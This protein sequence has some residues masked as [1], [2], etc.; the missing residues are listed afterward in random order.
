MKYK[1][2][3]EEQNRSQAVRVAKVQKQIGKVSS[4][5]SNVELQQFELREEMR[6]SSNEIKTEIQ[7]LRNDLSELANH[8]SQ[9]VLRK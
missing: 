5:V 6:A 1:D 8:F 7:Q 4:G 9:Y 3:S 2:I